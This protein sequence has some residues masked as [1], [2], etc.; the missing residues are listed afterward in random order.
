M[1]SLPV[2]RGSAEIFAAA[3]ALGLFAG[4]S[5]PSDDKKLDTSGLVPLTDLKDKEYRGFKGGLYPDGKNTRPALHD[6]AGLK[7]AEQVRPLD[8]QGKPSKDGK[9]VL[10]GIGFSNTVQGFNGFLQVAKDD[11]DIHT[12]VV[13]VN[14]AV[15]GMSA[16]M[17]QNP[18]DNGR[19]TKYWATVDERLKAAQSTRA[20]VQVIWLKETNPQPH[21]GG[22]PKYSEAL[23]GQLANIVRLLP[24]RFPNVKLVYISSRTYGGWAK[25]RPNGGPP[26]NSEPYSYETGFAVKWL[27]EEQLKGAAHLNFDPSKG[28]VK[29][30]WLSWGPYLWANGSAK[31]G[32]GFFFELGDYRADDQMHH[33][34]AGMVKIGRQLLDFFKTDPTTR[35]WF[36]RTPLRAG[37]VSDGQGRAGSVSDGLLD[38]WP[39]WR[40]P[41]A[42]GTAPQANPPI[43]WDTKTNI[44]WKAPLPGRGNATP[45]VWGNQVFVVTAVKTERLADP[46]DLPK[47][48]ASLKVKTT[49]PNCYYQFVV[50][51][52]D[53]QTGKLRW[54]NTATEKI[55]HE[56][57]QPTHS[58][59]GGSPA[60][61]GRF[62]YV[63]F[64]SFGIFCY[65]LDGKLQWQRD[66]GRLHTRYG[67]GEA[68]T[69]VCHGDS[70]LL[71]WDQE[72]DSA[73]I[74]L[75]AKT[76]KTKWRTE[77]DDKTSW[78][79]PL[80][81]AHKGQTQVIVNGTKRI[82]SYDLATGAELWQC[83]G[84]TINAIPSP[85]AANGIAYIMSG[86]T[87]AGAVAVPLDSRGDLGT[88]G[89]VAWRIHKGT[90]YVPSPLL[91]GDRLYFTQAN[92]MFYTVL[93]LKTGRAIADRE[94]LQGVDTFYA[95]PI[96]AAGRI[97]LVDRT[98]TTLVLRQADRVEVLA[99]NRLDDTIDASPA[100]VGRQLFLRSEKYLYCIQE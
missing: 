22:F 20:Q 81:V 79:T 67:W 19:G 68:V 40:G 50:L 14:G 7:L 82:R 95:S 69:P 16:E 21:L 29:A 97:Y 66:L 39:H 72:K 49:P 58:Y 73:L 43:T 30:P 57:I 34:A 74:C 52:F 26:G 61:D 41:N 18:N 33:S 62:L 86:Y 11:K 56:G 51:A 25:R 27:I 42:N 23:Q 53:R 70:L 6:L 84:M 88:D 5:C 47:V 10:L 78:N 1:V 91:A 44:K 12:Q 85:V 13:L 98:G 36:L 28:P 3:C 76:G 94:R 17:I 87:G 75:D 59:A 83:G 32:D 64:G 63:S 38:Q 92:T 89:K 77:R 55:P 2:G 24:E 93:D 60:T 54:K 96:A 48:D 90:P 100:A 71:N 9:T 46:A 37:S 4:V 99:T 31:R 45:I 35:G 15:G 8:A 80:V 65:D